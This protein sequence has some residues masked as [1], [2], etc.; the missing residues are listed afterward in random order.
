LAF[1]GSSIW[2][3]NF[4]T[5]SITKLTAAGETVGVQTVGTAQLADGAVTTSRLADGAV[6]TAKIDTGAVT[7]INIATDA[8]T[9]AK[10]V[11]GAVTTGKLAAGAVTTTSIADGAVTT[12]KFAAG[13][14][15]TATIAN[16][17]VTTAKIASGAVTAST[18]ANGGVTTANIAGGAVTSPT[19]AS[20]AVTTANIAD[21]AV[22]AAKIASSGVVTANIADNG[23]TMSKIASG[24]ISTVKIAD[25]AVTDAKISGPINSSKIS[26]PIYSFGGWIYST[27]P[28]GSFR[29]VGSTATVTATAGQRMTGTALAELGKTVAGTPWIDEFYYG[30]CRRLTGTITTPDPGSGT[31][32]SG[33]ITTLNVKQPF[34]ATTSILLDPG[35]WDVGFCVSVNSGVVLNH[36]G[37]FS[38]WVMLTN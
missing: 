7:G 11:D 10:I 1:D 27:F 2:V 34:V 9:A 28:T 18:I 22:T 30:I 33:K 23:V 38:G 21:G 32:F 19:I 37:N 8:V 29:F 20:G 16:S 12:V 17:S 31:W 24:A 35:T 14:V 4:G 3:A 36:N 5:N 25:G 13:A 15:T 6:T 26:I